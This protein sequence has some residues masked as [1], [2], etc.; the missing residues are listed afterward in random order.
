[1]LSTMVLVSRI[2][3]GPDNICGSWP[4]TGSVGVQDCAPSLLGQSPVPLQVW[5]PEEE[6]PATQHTAAHI[7]S[8]GKQ[9]RQTLYNRTLLLGTGC[10]LGGS[11]CR[12][13]GIQPPELSWLRKPWGPL[14]GPSLGSV[15]T[16]MYNIHNSPVWIFLQCRACIS[17]PHPWS[18][19]HKQGSKCFL[20][21]NPFSHDWAQ[22]SS[23][24]GA[25]PQLCRSLCTWQRWLGQEPCGFLSDAPL[26]WQAPQP[27]V[28]TRQQPVHI[29][30][31]WTDSKG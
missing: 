17:D 1:M 15:L 7:F 13:A 14:T 2:A 28:E 25:C 12:W 24:A 29:R 23:P 6:K 30:K 5:W 16:L 26:G 18:K 4:L 9:I 19:S 3:E 20:P 11:Q 22:P 31:C 21:V 27:S 10:A 8:C